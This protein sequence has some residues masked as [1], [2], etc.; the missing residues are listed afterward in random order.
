MMPLCQSG[1]QAF[2]VN[3]FGE[4]IDRKSVL[5]DKT[6]DDHEKYRRKSLHN[7]PPK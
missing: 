7:F 3:S 6:G 5:C 1:L 2:A 4:A